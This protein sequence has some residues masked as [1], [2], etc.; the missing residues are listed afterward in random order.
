MTDILVDV[1]MPY[2]VVYRPYRSRRT[3]RDDVKLFAKRKI[4]L[5][6]STA[7]EAIPAFRLTSATHTQKPD[8]PCII[9]LLDR[10]LW[11]PVADRLNKPMNAAKFLEGLA[12]GSHEY[13]QVLLPKQLWGGGH[14][15]TYERYFER[16]SR[17]EILENGI[18]NSFAEVQRWAAQ[19]MLCEDTVHFA[20]GAPAFFGS[21]DRA[22]GRSISLF[23]GNLSFEGGPRLTGQAARQ[24]ED[25]LWKGH[26]FDHSGLPREIQLMES[27]G[28]PIK[29]VHG[30][31]CV[32]AIAPTDDA[33]RLCAHA[34][35]GR[36]FKA[37]SDVAAAYRD[38]IPDECRR[39]HSKLVP[40]EICR[41][42]LTDAVQRRWPENF[43]KRNLTLALESIG[44]V[45]ARLELRAEFS[46]G[47][48][49]EEALASMTV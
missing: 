28:V 22:S 20:G 39:D 15:H 4:S 42:I 11:W 19:I 2:R 23:V 13:I 44:D 46:L 17:D 38:L 34:A 26:I 3:R 24:K 8:N 21:P 25:A 49:D 36:L 14:Q 6:V 31:E 33:L 32:G 37:S 1:N 48:D 45:L 10:K 7:A 35:V 41:N 47:P 18:E 5:T 30:I 29:V 12:S 9:R 43:G 27:R 40:P 16:R